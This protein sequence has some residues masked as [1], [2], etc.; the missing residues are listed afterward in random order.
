[1]KDETRPEDI[2][3]ADMTLDQMYRAFRDGMKESRND[4]VEEIQ[5]QLKRMEVLLKI[6]DLCEN[7]TVRS[8]ANQ[9]SKYCHVTCKSISLPM[10]HS[11]EKPRLIRPPT[12]RE[13]EAMILE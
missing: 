1:M 9:W 8:R 2:S 7:C 11:D 4:W 12:A 13:L 6:A 5:R 3:P 10:T